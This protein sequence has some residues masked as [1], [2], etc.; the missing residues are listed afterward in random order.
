MFKSIISPNLS[1]LAWLS[2]SPNFF[3]HNIVDSCC[4]DILDILAL[5]WP[6]HKKWSMILC[7]Y[8]W[9]FCVIISLFSKPFDNKIGTINM[10][11]RESSAYK[12]LQANLKGCPMFLLPYA[13]IFKPFAG[14][15]SLK[16]FPSGLWVPMSFINERYLMSA[17]AVLIF[18]VWSFSEYFLPIPQ[19][20]LK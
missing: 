1:L 4:T 3:P 13:D 10:Q 20:K 17:S 11:I 9:I 5:W 8:C 6:N 14:I 7:R 18:A 2:S 12:W 15:S 16:T 19:K